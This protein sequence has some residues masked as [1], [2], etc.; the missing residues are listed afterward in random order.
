MVVQEE[1]KQKKKDEF[2]WAQTKSEFMSLLRSFVQFGVAVVGPGKNYMLKS[3]SATFHPLSRRVQ[4]LLN[5]LKT[6]IVAYQC[7][8]AQSNGQW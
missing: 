2:I 4:R 8:L 5:K 7:K 6:G 3:P 1:E